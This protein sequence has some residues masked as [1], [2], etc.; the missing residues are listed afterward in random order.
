M[1]LVCFEVYGPSIIQRIS[2]CVWLLLLRFIF[3]TFCLRAYSYCSSI[4]LRVGFH[5]MNIDKVLMLFSPQFG[6]IVNETGINVFKMPLVHTYMQCCLMYL[7][8]ETLGSQ[9]NFNN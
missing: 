8:S 4:E 3:V 7:R 5:Y 9:I 1:V 6:E 2:F